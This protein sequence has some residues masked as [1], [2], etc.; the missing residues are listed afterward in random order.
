MLQNTLWIAFIKKCNQT[1]II[2]RPQTA[3]HSIFNFLYGEER[4]VY[5]E[6]SVCGA[7][8]ALKSAVMAV[9]RRQKWLKSVTELSLVGC[10]PAEPASVLL[11]FVR[12]FKGECGKTA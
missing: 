1:L 2:I 10:A 3:Y 8:N 12:E 7:K 6:R 4:N 11:A 5:L 9:K